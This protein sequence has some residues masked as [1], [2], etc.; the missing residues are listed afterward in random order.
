ML[1][2]FLNTTRVGAITRE[3]R[4][5][6]ISFVLDETYATLRP[7]PVLG[8][9]FEERREHRVFRQSSF[10]GELP[11]FFANLLPEGALQAMLQAQFSPENAAAT[12]A[13]VGEDL[14][15]AVIVRP[16]TDEVIVPP[17]ARAF[18]EPGA[19][20]APVDDG[21]RFSLGGVQLKFSAVESA[22][23][24]FTLPFRGMGGR[25]ILKFGSETYPKLPEN[26]FVTMTWAAA[27]GL[28]VP[29]H[30][31]IAAR[32]IEGLDNRFRALGEHVFAIE[33][34]DRGDDGGRVHQEDFAQVRGLPPERKYTG[35]SLDGMARFVGDL[36]GPEDLTEYLRRVL[37][38]LI[39][40]NTD[41]HLKNWSLI[42]PDGRTARLAPAYDF[43]C[44]RQYLP[45]ELA[46]PLAKEKVLDQISWDH[47][48]RVE[49]FLRSHGHITDFE[50]T[51]RD[52]V[53]RCLDEWATIRPQAQPEHRK[54]IDEHIA[55][56]PLVRTVGAA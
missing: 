40:C 18:E 19:A 15:G 36:C 46:L 49:R 28:K 1:E 23:Q 53:R 27:S 10:P 12:L 31:L 47:V 38:L 29:R 51:G 48:A 6:I 14:P 56:S 26:E 41:A 43:V 54:V 20:T 4:T 8:Q 55:R 37:F 34:Y 16:T 17:K 22:D 24:R 50:R 30:R 25:W 3:E 44:V 2:V 52:F 7:R 9:Q 21:L 13:I 45:Q 33:R 39:C 32:D 42:Y 5:G 11:T 35:W